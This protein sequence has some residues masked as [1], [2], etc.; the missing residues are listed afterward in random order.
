LFVEIFGNRVLSTG[1]S[2]EVEVVAEYD[3]HTSGIGFLPDGTGIVVLMEQKEIIRISDGAVHADLSSLGGEYLNDMV[4]D[5]TGRAWVD[6]VTGKSPEAADG[7]AIV[8]VDLD[9]DF[10]IAARG[11]LMRPNGIAIARDRTTLISGMDPLKTLAAWTIGNDGTL[12]DR[13]VYAELGNEGIDGLCVDAESAVWVA[14]RHTGS[15]G[16]AKA[17]RS[18]EWS[19]P[20]G[21][22]GLFHAC[23]EALTDGRFS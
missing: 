9:G 14:S 19:N 22:D 10:R 15:S 5:D 7:D 13:R 8:A 16:F 18:P 17:A 3:D 2:G 6:L 20:P 4:V 11:G 12:V 23:S 1:F 21:T